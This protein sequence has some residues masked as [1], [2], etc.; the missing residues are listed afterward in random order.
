MQ[1]QA[2]A[3]ECSVEAFDE[4]VLDRLARLN[5]VELHTSSVGPCIE[6]AAAELGAVVRDDHIGQASGLR[7]PLHH[8]DHP[9]RPESNGRPGSPDTRD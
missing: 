2:L 6:R 5:E 7:E 9:R 8:L 3:P 4:S 1:V